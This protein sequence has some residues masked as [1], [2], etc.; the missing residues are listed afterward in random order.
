MDY[1]IFGFLIGD[2]IRL[3]IYS[4]RMYRMSS[5]GSERDLIFGTIM[6]S[7]T[8]MQLFLYLL[9][10]ARDKKVTKEELMK[11]IWE[12]NNLCASPQRLWQ[13]LTALNSKLAALGLDENFIVSTK[14][15]GYQV[16]YC[17]ITPLYLKKN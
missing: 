1:Q 5:Y 10:N 8:M 12:D 6:F 7:E 3:D 11:K 9:I 15:K 4:R 13:V 14:G 16:K 2:D 17:D